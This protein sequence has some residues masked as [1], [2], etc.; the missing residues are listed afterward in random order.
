M[1]A[2]LIYHDNGVGLS[3]DAEIISNRLSILGCDVVRSECHDHIPP[4]ALCDI[5][6]YLELFDPWWTGQARRSY[7][8]PNQE[9]LSVAHLPQ[10]A[11]LE[12]VLCKTRFAEEALRSYSRRTSYIGFTS[13][14]RHR[15]AVAKDSR[16]WLHLLG[17]SGQKGTDAVIEAWLANP[18][19]PLLT[20]LH[21]PENSYAARILSSAPPNIVRIAEYVSQDDLMEI[22]NSHEV[23][24]CPSEIEGFGH[25][26]NEALSCKAVVVTTDAPPM[27][28]LVTVRCGVPVPWSESDEDPEYPG[29]TRR[30]RVTA[31]RLANTVRRV[32]SLPHSARVQIGERARVDYEARDRR[33]TRAFDAFM[34]EHC[35][36]PW[37]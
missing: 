36:A 14:D 8:I 6:I 20:V 37:S 4:A 25:S 34:F 3:A 5:N 35:G 31:E 28:E 15:P 30:Y 24:V 2:N 9:W 18:D 12:G 17:R 22:M 21:H 19:F 11:A 1:R 33:F 26:L 16:R 29:I 13:R 10:I 7:L 32:M 23:H 27:N